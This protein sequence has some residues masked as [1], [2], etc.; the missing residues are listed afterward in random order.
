MLS[1]GIYNGAAEKTY[2]LCRKLI[3]KPGRR[4]G[5]GTAGRRVKRLEN[6]CNTELF[7]RAKRR[8]EERSDEFSLLNKF[9]IQRLSDLN[10][11]RQ[12]AISL[13]EEQS[14]IHIQQRYNY[15]AVVC[16]YS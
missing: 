15:A 12:S 8:V 1:G 11:H 7:S 3:T 2:S 14:N 4:A 6:K 13:Q 5:V 16:V 9:R 10:I